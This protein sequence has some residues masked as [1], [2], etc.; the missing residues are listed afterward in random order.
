MSNPNSPVV[1]TSAK[2]KAAQDR[3]STLNPSSNAVNTIIDL[4]VVVKVS[5]YTNTIFVNLP[6]SPIIKAV[7]ITP[8][9]CTY[10]GLNVYTYPNIGDTVLVLRN[11]KNST[12]PAWV[13]AVLPKTIKNGAN[14]DSNHVGI[15]HD[16]INITGSKEAQFRANIEKNDTN[17]FGGRPI[18]LADYES[19]MGTPFGPCVDF[20]QTLV[21]LKASDL[22]KIECYL[23]DDFV[24]IVSQNFQHISAFG[25]FD[26]IA[27]NGALDV[28]WTGS[29]N[30]CDTFGKESNNQPKGISATNNAVDGLKVDEI[31]EEFYKDGRWRFRQYIGKLGN[32]LH[33]M[34]TEPMVMLGKN[35]D[36]SENRSGT[37]D[38]YTGA[39]GT[40]LVRSIAEIALEKV[41]RIPVP[42]F[43]VKPEELDV[44]NAK[45]DA[46]A[47]WEPPDTD[48]LW[49]VSYMLK[50]YNRWLSNYYV[51]ASFQSFGASKVNIP[52]ESAVSEPDVS[53]YDEKLK[54]VYSSFKAAFGEYL[55]R[56]STIRIFRDGSIMCLDG[57]GST[58]HMNGGDIEVSANQN[59]FLE[60]AGIV[61]ITAKDINLLARDTVEV[62][63]IKKRAVLK[64]GSSVD[65]Y[66]QKGPVLVQSDMDGEGEGTYISDMDDED[67]DRA[68]NAAGSGIVLKTPQSNILINTQKGVIVQARAYLNKAF[69]VAFKSMKFIID[70]IAS[71]TLSK[72][73]FS[74]SRLTVNNLYA[75]F[76]SNKEAQEVAITGQVGLSA[77]HDSNENED[78]NE[79]EEDAQQD[80]NTPF[81]DALEKDIANEFTF[82]YKTE[83]LLTFL[84]VYETMAQQL[85]RVEKYDSEHSENNMYEPYTYNDTFYGN[86][87]INYPLYPGDTHA[88]NF[89][90]YTPKITTSINE[91]CTLSGDALKASS[92]QR[93]IQ[94]QRIKTFFLKED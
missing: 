14:V 53:H 10:L 22:A 11:A 47:Q 64:G 20:L 71:F 82:S 73:A 21:R 77:K 56:Y 80:D 86:P 91:P 57:Y 6:K 19:S 43:K 13:I 93:K 49:E 2:G 66:S 83:E 8:F 15:A 40:V 52:A 27:N 59:L 4:G 9:I 54:S 33:L 84:N 92:L 79:I 12:S 61:N 38:I 1:P 31:I 50:D 55:T 87:S 60:A 65:I 3:Y 85:I 23:L 69:T 25:N 16:L 34:V 90:T 46:Y 26:I 35:P 36:G 68:D 39:D 76:I 5:P 29:Y 30:E 58:I 81:N 7:Y 18:D 70:K 75:N 78:K 62:S 63:A 41:V 72:V 37:A 32:I 28:I 94:E 45:M 44:A 51:M 74:T 89:K 24:R 48:A 67:A 88:I 17:Y 42:V